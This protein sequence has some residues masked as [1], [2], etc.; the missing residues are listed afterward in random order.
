[1]NHRGANIALIYQGKMNEHDVQ[2][3]PNVR[4]PYTDIGRD[5]NFLKNTVTITISNIGQALADKISTSHCLKIDTDTVKK[6]VN[7]SYGKR[8]GKSLNR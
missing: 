5:I 6:V 4:V 3:C 7:P 8:L 2:D 1:M